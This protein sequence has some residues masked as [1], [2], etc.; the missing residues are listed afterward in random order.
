[1]ENNR[2]YVGCTGNVARRL[3][4]HNKRLS[5]YTRSKG[6]WEL[7]YKEEFSNLRLARKREKQIKGWKKRAAIERLIQGAF[8]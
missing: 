8:V 1:M 6:P 7:V 3:D 5:K 2:Y 4:E